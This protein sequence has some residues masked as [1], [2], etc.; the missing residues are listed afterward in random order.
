MGNEPSE[1]EAQSM[2]D[3]F[4]FDGDNSSFDRKEFSEFWN[5][6]RNDVMGG[7]RGP[8]GP[9]GDRGRN[10]GGPDLGELAEKA[11]MNRDK[12]ISYDELRL[13]G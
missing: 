7:N 5:M 11:D 13:F 6:M 4:N 9:D 2:L 12:M 3:K 8:G 10:G 1:K